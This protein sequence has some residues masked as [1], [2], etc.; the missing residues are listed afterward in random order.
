MCAGR[1]KNDRKGKKKGGTEVG[2]AKRAKRKTSTLETKEKK[3]KNFGKLPGST[4]LANQDKGAEEGFIRIRPRG[5]GPKES[6]TELPEVKSLHYAR[7]NAGR[8]KTKKK[9]RPPK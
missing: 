4:G 5:A 8:G 7:S 1:D 2:S 3:R 9:K 6:K